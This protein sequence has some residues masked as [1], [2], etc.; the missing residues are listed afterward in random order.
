VDLHAALPSKYVDSYAR[1]IYSDGT[2]DYVVGY[3]L[4]S[5]T[6]KNEAILWKRPAAPFSFTLNKT[7]I[8]GQN[9][10]QGTIALPDPEPSPAVVTTYDNSSLVS[11]PPTVTVPTGATVK[12]FAISVQAV[13]S[14]INTTVYAKWRGVTRSRPLTLAP[15]VP[16]AL[17]FNPN[18][19]A[20]GGTVVGRVVINGVAGPGG[21]TIALIDDSPYASGPNTVIVPPGASD[22]SF[23]IETVPVPAQKTVRVTARVSAGEK[24][25]TFRINP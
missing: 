18:P 7:S 4:N 11:T 15:L 23:D 10:V 16:T 19:V 24:S 20:G 3:A 6:G 8:A 9:T 13:N 21:R 2:F 5:D 12:L 14:P 17:A 25:G 22:V 1:A